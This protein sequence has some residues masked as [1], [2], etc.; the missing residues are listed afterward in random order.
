MTS[1]GKVVATIEAIV[2]DLP[3]VSYKQIVYEAVTNAIQAN[4]T[5]ID[6]IFHYNI[7]DFDKKDVKDNEKILES[8]EIVD[9][10][11]G[12]TKKI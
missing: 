2:D 5:N 1:K 7:L 4:A 9:D 6:I 10:G 8:I 11:E 3:Q 12:F